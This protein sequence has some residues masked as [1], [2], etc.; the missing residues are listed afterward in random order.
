MF[1]LNF[2][3][4]SVMGPAG[5]ASLPF[6]GAV[7]PRYASLSSVTPVLP[8]PPPMSMLYSSPSSTLLLPESFC[9]RPVIGLSDD[10]AK[11]SPELNDNLCTE[12]GLMSASSPT[13]L[14]RQ[15]QSDSVE[16]IASSALS[17]S[18]RTHRLSYQSL[19]LHTQLE[20]LRHYQQQQQQQQPQVTAEE[21]ESGRRRCSAATESSTS[22]FHQP[23]RRRRPT[24]PDHITSDATTDVISAEHTPHRTSSPV[25]LHNHGDRSPAR[26]A[27]KFFYLYSNF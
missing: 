18:S 15:R 5:P 23:H 10:S 6:S 16:S 3:A 26:K 17:A 2:W 4:Q 22:A 24:T 27:G 9:R 1:R 13:M 12:A 25:Q 21:T 8:P 11:S 20:A 14:G 7:D 19:L